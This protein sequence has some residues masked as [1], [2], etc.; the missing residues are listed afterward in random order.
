MLGCDLQAHPGLSL[1]DD[2]M[3]EADREYV[4]ALQPVENLL[5]CHCVS[6]PDRHDRAQVLGV[7][8]L[9]RGGLRPFE[10]YEGFN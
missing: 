10:Q 1:W 9:L 7:P 6:Y 5:R 2:W 3:A 8:V 4:L